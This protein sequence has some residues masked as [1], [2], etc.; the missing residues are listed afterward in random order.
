MDFFIFNTYFLQLRLSEVETQFED[1]KRRSEATRAQGIQTI[2]RYMLTQ[3]HPHV[4]IYT[5]M[6][7]YMCVEHVYA[8]NDVLYV[9]QVQSSV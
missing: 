4:C 2:K 5:Y 6:Y 8:D 9:T 3:L 7:M 1:S